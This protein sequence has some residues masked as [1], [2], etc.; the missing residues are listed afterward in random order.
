[1]T[2]LSPRLIT[3]AVIALAGVLCLLAA[4]L[5][6]GQI[7]S[8][9]AKA[10]RAAL[11]DKG[12]AWT[13]ATPDGMLM[14]LSGTAPDEAA[15]FRALSAAGEV[16]DASHVLDEITVEAANPLAAPQ[17]SVELLR[18]A[19]GISVIGLVPSTTD[20]GRLGRDLGRLARDLSV[21][22]ML[23]SAT[24]PVPEG[25]EAALAF[26]INALGRFE[27]AKV[28]IIPG[29]VSVSAI[30]PNPR[31]RN[32]IAREL[33]AAA[34]TGLTPVLEISAPRP[35]IAPFTL[36][37][38][39]EGGTARF[40]ACAAD[41]PEAATLIAE[42]ARRAGLTG[43]LDCPLGLGVPAPGWGKAAAHGIDALAEIGGGTLAFSDANV[44]LVAVPGTERARFDRAVA[45]LRTALTAP[46]ELTATLPDPAGADGPDTAE[47]PREF[48]AT[49]SPKGKVQLRGRVSDALVQSAAESYARARFGLRNVRSATR[50][51][52][53][54]PEGW[55]IRVLAGLEALSQLRNGTVIVRADLVRISGVTMDDTAQARVARLLS[56][57]LGEGQ[58]FEIDITYVEPEETPDGRPTPE[59]CVARIGEIIAEEKITFSP[60]SI[61]IE[62]AAVRVVD[63][64][65]E[66]LRSCPDAR[67]EIG[68]H[69]DSQGRA[70]LN[71]RLSRERAE[72][73]LT[74]LMARRVLTSN[75]TARGYGASQP[76]ADNGT[77][78]GREAN[79]RIEFQ[80]VAAE[81]EDVENEEAEEETDG[82]D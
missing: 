41:T 26:G 57:R 64:I 65:A 7:E 19:S 50:L 32:R 24:A 34:P 72:A 69:T 61:R 36:R 66:V 43:A 13:E 40:D 73:V 38:V 49:L 44:T 1:M 29:E 78:E 18:N 42:A 77:E 47:G 10:V 51:D 53:G 21:T 16:I 33:R 81:P 37:F 27:S 3:T 60:G 58:S 74:A 54:L 17:F 35:M 62:G 28:S 80:L 75:L 59:A 2:R 79:R 31:E 20:R 4:F 25:W 45:A 14:R 46:F 9:T 30:A 48:V 70:A 76:I 22:D 67:I 12:I 5:A 56:D 82:Q 39:L 8:R 63:Q 23:E 68:G 6:V 52:P 55:P 71:E 15:R 11:S